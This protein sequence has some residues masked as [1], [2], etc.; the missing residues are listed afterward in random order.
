MPL[1]R[2]SSFSLAERKLAVIK[3]NTLSRTSC[4]LP[5]SGAYM[6]RIRSGRMA[7]VDDHHLR[8]GLGH[9]GV[10]E[11]Q[12]HRARADDQ[13]IRLKCCHTCSS[14]WCRAV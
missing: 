6:C 14:P 12:A 9:Q 3:P 7:S 2:A 10:G 13:V 1:S 8:V 4:D 11:R 5:I